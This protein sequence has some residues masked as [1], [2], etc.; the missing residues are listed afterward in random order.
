MS[1]EH[2]NVE[3]WLISEKAET[4]ARVSQLEASNIAMMT[5]IMS[6]RKDLQDLVTLLYGSTE[7]DPKEEN[8]A[9]TL[10]EVKMDE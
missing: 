7:S 5:E 2:E 1:E 8:T 6:L 10:E 3:M 9:E 4:L